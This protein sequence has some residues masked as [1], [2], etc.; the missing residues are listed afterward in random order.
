M[1]VGNIGR[2]VNRR[3]REEARIFFGV[4]RVVSD[5]EVTVIYRT[6]PTVAAQHGVQ[7]R[8]IDELSRELAGAPASLPARI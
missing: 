2:T 5:K 8:E 6:I 4:N 3:S 7:L 1:M